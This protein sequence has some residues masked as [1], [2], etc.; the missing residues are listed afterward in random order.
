LEENLRDHPNGTHS[1]FYSNEDENDNICF[2]GVDKILC[3]E[4]RNHNH[5]NLLKNIDALKGMDFFSTQNVLLTTIGE[6]LRAKAVK[7]I[8]SA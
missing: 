7:N 6:Q 1:S 4:G 3:S 2:Y 5:Q 8:H